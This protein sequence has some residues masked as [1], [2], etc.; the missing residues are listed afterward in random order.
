MW[1]SWWPSG[2][3]MPGADSCSCSPTMCTSQ[4]F[5][6]LP[7]EPHKGHMLACPALVW[8]SITTFL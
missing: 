7:W 5:L 8:S 6:P 1:S 2:V 4:R 3:G